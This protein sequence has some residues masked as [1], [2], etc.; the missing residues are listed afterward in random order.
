MS[1]IRRYYPTA[2]IAGS[3]ALAVVLSAC[4]GGTGSP[5][6]KAAADTPDTP[7]TVSVNLR[8]DKAR[9]GQ[10]VKVTAADGRLTSVTVADSEGGTLTGRLAPDGTTW[11]S[12][13]NALPGTAYSVTAKTES[14]GGA[15]GSARASF[16][17]V[18][19]DKVNKVDW[20]PGDRATV[21][22]AQ[23][24]SL[25]FDNPVKNK[26]EVEKHLKV[27]TSDNTEGSWGWMRDYSGRDRVDWRPRDYWKPGTKVKLTAELKGVDSGSSG[28]WFVRDYGAG[29]TVG[30][31]QVIKVDLDSKQLTLLRDGKQVRKIPV[32]GGTPGGDQRSWKGTAVLIAKEGTVKMNSETVGFG[33]AYNKDVAYS[34]R[35]TWSGMYAHAAPW[36]AAYFGNANRSH[37]CI[38]M[39][40]EN[41]AALFREAQPG[42]PFEIKGADTKG[43]VA[44]NN[45]FGEW[46]LSWAEW[47]ARAR[48]TAARTA[49]VTHHRRRRTTRP[50]SGLRGLRVHPGELG[51]SADRPVQPG[52]H[53]IDLAAGGQPDH[54]VASRQHMPGRPRDGTDDHGPKVE[55]RVVAHPGHLLRVVAP[56][57]RQLVQGRQRGGRVVEY[58]AG[59]ARSDAQQL[60][61]REQLRHPLRVGVDRLRRPGRL[62]LPAPVVQE[63]DVHAAQ[64]PIQVHRSTTG[65]APP[66]RQTSRSTTTGAWSDAPLPLRSSRST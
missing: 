14:K 28:G 8:G 61:L 49:D 65:R 43:T 5:D 34:M 50:A 30:K 44:L 39:S 46:N 53:H 20:R 3:A 48:C 37:G 21:G 52:L 31:Q 23:P 1:H 27:T 36:N 57:R 19:A 63:R 7:A 11:T 22:V 59:P 10:P 41:A 42:D 2:A 9:P 51:R 4:S 15:A 17:T 6:A 16:T 45:G 35:L 62:M 58:E 12:D 40:D 55:A 32:S 18:T 66:P 64:P 38:G 47:Q 56:V 26:A 25:V 24:I 29:F 33:D 54:R 60:A 13:R